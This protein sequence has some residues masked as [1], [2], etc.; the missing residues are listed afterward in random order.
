[1]DLLH[2]GMTASIIG[3][4]FIGLAVLNVHRHIIREHKIDKRVFKAMG[5]EKIIAMFGIILMIA[6]Y[7]VQSY[8]YGYFGT[9]LG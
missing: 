3:E 1:M 2:I 7:L 4:V 9:F 8:T 6:G 5:R